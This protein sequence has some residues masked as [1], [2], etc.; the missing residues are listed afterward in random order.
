[1]LASVG[2][3]SLLV[4]TAAYFWFIQQY[5]VNVPYADQWYSD[6]P[7]LGD[8]FSHRLT[9]GN[10]WA[11]HF[12]H[13]MLFPNLIVLAL[14]QFTHFNIIVE[15]YLGAVFLV[16][17]VGLFILAH[18]KRSP[19]TPWI[20]YFPVTLLLFSFVQYQNSLW[21][22]QMAWYLVMLAFARRRCTSST[23]LA[24]HR[25]ANTSCWCSPEP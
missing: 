23:R 9:L 25:S 3:L 24:L 21:G 4:P 10:L 11:L 22:F 8:Y 2:I 5:A 12:D 14:A 20:Y 16:V 19:S 13:R 17:S 15:D 6:V 7:L 18:K 1:M